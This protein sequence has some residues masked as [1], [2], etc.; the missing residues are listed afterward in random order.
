LRWSEVCFL[1]LEIERQEK[2]WETSQFLGP[3]LWVN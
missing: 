3:F 1:R 2:H